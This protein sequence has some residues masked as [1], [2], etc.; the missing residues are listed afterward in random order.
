M[1]W[2]E[3]DPFARFFDSW[4]EF[5]RIKKLMR[6]ISSTSEKEFPLINIWAG[7]DIAVVMTEIPGVDYKDVDISVLNNTL[8]IRGARQPEKIEEGESYHRRERWHGQFARTIELPFNI[9]SE[10]V[11]ARFIKGVLYISL[12]RAEADKPKKVSI[13]SE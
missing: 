2:Y 13:K 10:K 6:D 12:P 5:D 4:R 1:V 3:I 8:T 9:E 11:E 7:N